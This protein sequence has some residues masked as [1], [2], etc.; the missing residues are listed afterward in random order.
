MHLHISNLGQQ[1]TESSL[2][3]MFA[4]YGTVSAAEIMMDGFTGQSRGFG[5]V[6]MPEATEAMLAIEKVSGSVIDGKPV[7]VTATQPRVIHRGSYPA[8]RRANA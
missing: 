4:P 6:E 5:F 1:I 2:R 8:G 3:V 7:V